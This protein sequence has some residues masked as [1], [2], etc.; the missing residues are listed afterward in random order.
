MTHLITQRKQGI[1][2]KFSVFSSLELFIANVQARITFQNGPKQ[3]IIF[4]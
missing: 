1:V 2:L 3:D 4:R